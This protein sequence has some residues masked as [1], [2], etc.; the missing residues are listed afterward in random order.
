MTAL[1]MNYRTGGSVLTPW[2]HRQ[3]DRSLTTLF[4]DVDAQSIHAL[5]HEMEWRRHGERWPR[6]VMSPRW[7]LCGSGERDG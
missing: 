5:Q 2:Q 4:G 7:N 1:E 3:L 6:P